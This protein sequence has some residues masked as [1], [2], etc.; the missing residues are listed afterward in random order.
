LP[1]YD[2][3]CFVNGEKEICESIGNKLRDLRI[4]NG[5]SSYEHFAIENELSRMQYWRIEKGL[6]NLTLRSLITLLNIHKITIEEFF[7]SLNMLDA[8][9]KL[10]VKANKADGKSPKQKVRSKKNSEN[11]S[12]KGK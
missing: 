10:D 4:I 9:S 3:F 8:N 2:E 5:Y 1:E 7:L 11:S 12:K 6:T